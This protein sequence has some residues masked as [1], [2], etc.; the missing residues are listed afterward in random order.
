MKNT[1]IIFILTLIIMSC[2]HSKKTSKKNAPIVHEVILANDFSAYARNSANTQILNATITDSILSLDISYNGGCKPHTFDLIG[3]KMIQKSMPPIRG[4]MLAHNDN[5]D[6]CRELIEE[7][8]KFN[9]NKFRYP[10]Q[11]IVLKLQ[12]YEPRILFTKTK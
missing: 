10:N 1:F 4:I 3:S 6:D 7:T 5:E 9:I 2:G 8:I 11:D 12:G